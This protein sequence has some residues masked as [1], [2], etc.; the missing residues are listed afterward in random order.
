MA[1]RYWRQTLSRALKDA[2]RAMRLES[3]EQIIVKSLLAVGA[4]AVA[5]LMAGGFDDSARDLA[6]KAVYGLVTVAAV[7]ALIFVYSLVRTIARQ[8]QEAETEIASLKAAEEGKRSALHHGL[9]D[10][11]ATGNKL[12]NQR[13]AS[14]EELENWI[15]SLDHWYRVGCTFLEQSVSVGDKITFQNARGLSFSYSLKFNQQHENYLNWL[16]PR[17]DRLTAIMD[18]VSPS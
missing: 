4:I 1:S 16:Q 5:V 17:I 14:D 3:M 12:Y 6:R 13:L 8:Q 10:L 18:R 2:L 9:A 7:L 11:I 15:K